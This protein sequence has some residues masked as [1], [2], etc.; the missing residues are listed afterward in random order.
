MLQTYAS[1]QWNAKV[2]ITTVWGRQLT[3]QESDALSSKLV[4]LID[5]GAITSQSIA[6]DATVTRFW[7]VAADGN[8]WASFLNTFTPPPQSCVVELI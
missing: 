8:V 7:S 3:T 6:D 5:A 4:E 1:A 2:K